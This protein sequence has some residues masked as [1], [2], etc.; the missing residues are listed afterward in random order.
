MKKFLGL[1]LCIMFVMLTFVNSVYATTYN[2]DSF[3][4]GDGYGTKTKVDDNITNLKGETTGPYSKASTAKLVDGIIEK[5][6]VEINMEDLKQGELFE[7][8]VAL[9]NLQNEY[10]SEEV[11]MTQKIN[12]NQVKVT[13]NGA[14][15]FAVIV[16]E[17]GVYTY[18]W[19][20]FIKNNK[21][22]VKFTLL[23]NETVIGTTGEI[24][25]DTIV[26][27]D[28][29]NPIAEEEDVSV[30]YL[31]FCNVQVEKGVNVYAE[32]P[33]IE[34]QP[35]E[36]EKEQPTEDEKQ[37]VE[38]EKEE[39]LPTQEE[40]DKKDEEPKMGMEVSII[41]VLAVIAMVALAGY[42]VTKK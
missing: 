10:V 33:V 36:E 7:I 22:F 34:E 11:V 19:E 3:T 1:T 9:K 41:T 24:D 14:P 28:T 38:D 13:A 5:V 27:S 40:T 20:I 37:P 31:W 16:D 30:R 15:D 18:Q 17:S 29:K 32:L 39:E 8:S 12:E 6:H 21:T 2:Y 35:E 42:V 26:T 23:N 25:F 4:A